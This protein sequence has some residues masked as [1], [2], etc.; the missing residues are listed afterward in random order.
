ME[1]TITAGPSLAWA[2]AAHISCGDIVRMETLTRATR[3]NIQS[4]SVLRWVT[5]QKFGFSGKG[6]RTV[7]LYH[8]GKSD[9]QMPTTTDGI[10]HTHM[11]L[12]A[13]AENNFA[14]QTTQKEMVNDRE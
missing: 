12:S 14:P 9:T 7:S 13:L 6:K 1:S 2:H 4:H 3:L 11:K 8:D 5:D 10:F